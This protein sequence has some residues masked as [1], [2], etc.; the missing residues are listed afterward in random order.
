M[1]QQLLQIISKN[2]KLS[3]TDMVAITRWYDG[4]I[5]NTED[6]RIATILDMLQWIYERT[7]HGDSFLFDPNAMA[8]LINNFSKKFGVCSQRSKELLERYIAQDKPKRTVFVAIEGL[9]GSGKTVQCKKLVDYL[10]NSG[11]R[12]FYIDFPQ[13][14][15]FIGKEI[16]YFLSGKD[17]YTNADS[18]DPKSMCLWYATDRWYALKNVDFSNYDFV[19]FNRYTL[20]SAVYQT[21]RFFNA[22]NTEFI[23][24]VFELEHVIYS[25]PTPDIYLFLDTEISGCSENLTHKGERSYVEGLDLYERS[26]SLLACCREIYHYCVEAYPNVRVIFCNGPDGLLPVEDIH[27]RILGELNQLGLEI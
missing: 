23:N 17:S 24:W 13:Y 26:K 22:V 1:N 3:P 21:A 10:T 15:S 20:S 16:G 19:I 11:K 27:H 5:Y 12:V 8:T 2:G 14:N 6:A 7:E 9:D 4:N 18:I 25:L